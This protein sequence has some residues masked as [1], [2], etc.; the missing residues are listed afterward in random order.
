MLG[1]QWS[2]S[3]TYELENVTEHACGHFQLVHTRK[4]LNLIPAMF[5]E[6]E[7]EKTLHDLIM[8]SEQKKSLYISP[9]SY[10]LGLAWS[11]EIAS[12]MA[13]DKNDF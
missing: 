8:S 11:V 13:D 2:C 5:S 12:D 7:G 4:V 1:E 3:R 10:V 9:D 6:K